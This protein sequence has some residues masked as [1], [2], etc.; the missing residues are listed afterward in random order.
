MPLLEPVPDVVSLDLLRSVAESG[1]IRQAALVHGVTQPAASARLR[2]L[3]R[4]L[5]LQLLDRSHGHARLT[6]EGMAVVEWS[7]DVLETMKRLIL[8]TQALREE[9]ET[10][11]RVAAS[12]TVAEYLIPRW[13]N[14]LHESDPSISV[15]LE[16][17]NSHHVVDTMQSDEADLGFVE[18]KRPPT[19]MSSRTVCSDDLVL[20]VDPKSKWARRGVKVRASELSKTP[21]VLREAGSG[22]RE[23]L[24][25]SLRDLGLDVIA[26]VELGSTTAIK[27]AVAA[28]LGPAV[29]S[30]LVVDSD[31]REGR[32]VEVPLQDI[33]F[34]RSIR[35]VWPK[36]RS[37]SPSAKRLLFH[38]NASS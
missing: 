34:K 32:L 23:V 37:L 29:L 18:G 33:S 1:S 21:L 2:S 14:S 22:T 6:A 5:G 36:G 16:M 17:G 26:L 11:L 9:G 35:A 15:S 7:D 12:M 24:E 3:E 25:T 10:R 8:G 30:R 19:G 38:I 28:G 31:V 4:S 20:V 13:L 27:T